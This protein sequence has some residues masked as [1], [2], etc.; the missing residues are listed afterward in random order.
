M[1]A[2]PTTV[3]LV[4]TSLLST[5]AE[6]DEAV[7]RFTEVVGRKDGLSAR[8]IVLDS[9]DCQTQYGVRLGDPGNWEEIRD[10]LQHNH[11]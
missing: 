8:Y 5:T 7:S 1:N 9:E 11:R 10:V 3:L 4:T 6:L 2:R